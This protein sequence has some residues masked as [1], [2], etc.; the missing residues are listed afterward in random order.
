MHVY[1]CLVHVYTFIMPK[2]VYAISLY[3]CD[4]CNILH[5]IFC[6]HDY[7]LIFLLFVQPTIE[8]ASTEMFLSHRGE[9]AK[10]KTAKQILKFVKVQTNIHFKFADSQCHGE[11]IVA[12]GLAQVEVIACNSSISKQHNIMYVH[13][14]T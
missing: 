10:V 5:A 7:L 6:M 9:T 8:W 12:Q 3:Y 1:Y 13:A 2:N 4:A 14:C 11:P